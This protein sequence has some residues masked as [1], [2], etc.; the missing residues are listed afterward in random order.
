MA[1]IP[2]YHDTLSQLYRSFGQ[3]IGPDAA[4]TFHFLPELH[5]ERPFC[6]PVFRSGYFSFVFVKEGRGSYTLD[7]DTHPFGPFTVYFT[8]PGHLKSFFIEHLQDGWLLTTTE[9][10]LRAHVAA[11]VFEQFPFLLNQTVPPLNFG[12]DAY[13]ELETLYQPIRQEVRLS[14]PYQSQILGSLLVSLL[15]KLKTRVADLPAYAP[16]RSQRIVHAFLH[17]L[18]VH[19]TAVYRQQASLLLQTQDYARQLN[20]HPNYLNQVVKRQTG[21]TASQWIQDRQLATAQSLL[22][23]T[24]LSIKEISERMGFSAPGHFSRFFKRETRQSP[25]EYRADP[26]NL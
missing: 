25:A 23:H 9:A 3:I 5:P 17:V 1:S 15:Y 12:P 26:V 20:L 7:A 13:A 24:D 4:F 18:E 8:N 6:S 19:H 11:D 2:H 10:F 21:K 22:R 14:G 16:G